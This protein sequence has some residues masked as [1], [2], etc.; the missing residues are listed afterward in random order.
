MTLVHHLNHLPIFYTTAI[1]LF[2]VVVF[3]PFNSE[4]LIAFFFFVNNFN[5]RLSQV[6]SITHCL[7]MHLGEG[8]HECKQQWK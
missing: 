7:A 2:C 6:P 8:V 1:F 5:F 4:A 3:L